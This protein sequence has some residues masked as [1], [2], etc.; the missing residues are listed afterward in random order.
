[1]P[2]LDVTIHHASG[3][4][5]TSSRKS[6]CVYVRLQ[7]QAMRT[8]TASMSGSGEVSFA[9]RFRFQYTPDLRR[10]ERNRLFLELWTKS[11]FS[12]ACVSVAWLELD[13][14]QFYRGQ[15][16]RFNLQGGF[17]NKSSTLTLSVTPLDFGMTTATPTL[18]PVAQFT[19]PPPGPY[20]PPQA[21]S[22][23][24]PPPQV[25]AQ[26]AEGIPLIPP[27]PY[28]TASYYP[29]AEPVMPASTFP[30][31][32]KE[33]PP[34]PPPNAFI[35]ATL[36]PPLYPSTYQQSTASAPPPDID[37]QPSPSGDMPQFGYPT[38]PL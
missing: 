4:S 32:Q 34:T 37:G 29:S 16:I 24:P 17:E 11:I 31:G 9:E 3:I 23:P 21:V 1:M 18:P 26:P 28:T 13:S 8:K 15:T 25:S 19:P 6:F 7:G 22:V 14:Q 33:A 2:V 5:G 27:N 12:Q 35:G 20:Y 10:R 38:K 36:P 30:P